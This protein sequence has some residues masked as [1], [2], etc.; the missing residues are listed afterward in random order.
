M[1]WLGRRVREDEGGRGRRSEPEMVST[2]LDF[3]CSA[4]LNWIL[5]VITI[6]TEAIAIQDECTRSSRITAI[7]Y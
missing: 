1:A 7:R 2:A 4:L 5:K 3:R 6:S